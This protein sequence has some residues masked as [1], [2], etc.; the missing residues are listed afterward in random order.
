MATLYSKGV[1]GNWS[2]LGTFNTLANGTGT[3]TAP[4]AADAVIIQKNDVVILDTN[5]AGAIV[6]LSVAL[7][8]GTTGADVG[9]ILRAS[10]TANSK[11]VVER[12]ITA[13]GATGGGGA[14]T[15]YVDLNM[16]A[17]SGYTCEVVTNNSNTTGANTQN[18][19][20]GN[21]NFKGAARTRHTTLTAGISA[22]ATSATVADATGWVAGDRIIF[23]TTSAYAS[24]PA[25][26]II[27]LGTVDTGTGAITWTGG[28]TYAHAAS[29]PVGNFSS[30]LILRP[31][32]A[33]GEF[34]LRLNSASGAMSA[35]GECTHVEFRQC[36]ASS[37]GSFLGVLGWQVGSTRAL[38]MSDN[39]F[40]DHN[41]IAIYFNHTATPTERK[42]NIFHSSQT[43]GN[44]A[45]ATFGFFGATTSAFDPGTDE[46][47]AIFRGVDGFSPV[48]PGQHQIGHKI[49][50]CVGNQSS[51]DAALQ[52]TTIGIRIENCDFWSNNTA[53]HSRVGSEL[54][55]CRFGD[56]VF[57]GCNNSGGILAGPGTHNA[58]DC[59]PQSGANAISQIAA[60]NV[61]GVLNLF[62][63]DGDSAV[64]EVYKLHS[65]TVPVIDRSVVAAEYT[66][67]TSSLR[68]TLNGTAT[69]EHEISVP[70]KAGE[71]AKIL[72]YVTRSNTNLPVAGD[73]NYAAGTY[74]EPSVTLSG[75]GITPVTASFSGTPG[76]FQLLTLDLSATPKPGPAALASDGLLTLTLSAQ[77]ATA[78]AQAFFAAVPV[79]PFVSRC[80]HYGYLFDETTITRTTNITIDSGISEATALAYG[81]SGTD[82]EVTWGAT[83]SL[84]VKVDSTF[85]KIYHFTQAD[86][87]LN[88]GSALPLTGAGVDDSPAL[89]AAGNVTVSATKTLNGPGSLEMGAYTL[90]GTMPWAY[91]YTGGTFSQSVA[92]PSFSG[93]T[94]NIGAAG[95][96]TFTQAA[97]M[98][99]SATPTAPSN[100]VL[101]AATFTGTLNFRNTSA[102]NI[103]VEIPSGVT[104]NST[105]SPGAG[106][107]TFVAPVVT[108]DISITGMSNT[109]GANNRLQIINQTAVAAA[110]WQAAHAYTAGD[111]VLRTSGIGSENTAGL[112]MRCTVSGTSGA[113]EPTWDTT[114]GNTTAD[115]AGTL[116]WTTYAILYY[117][118][119]PAATSLTD[120]YIDGEE[121]KAGETVEI[122]FAEEDPAVSFK[123]YS[124]SV[125]A[126]ADGFSALVNEEADDSYATY[127][128]SGVT[129][130][131]IFSPN[132]VANYIVLDTDTNFTGSGAYAYYCYLLTT[133]EG[134]YRFWG[135][136]TGIDPGNIR[137]NVSVVSLYFD[138]SS[139]FV[140]QT[141]DIRVFRSDGLRPA[142]DPVTAAGGGIEINWKVPVNVVSTGGSALTPTESAQLLALPSAATTAAAVGARTVE[143][144][145]SEDEILKLLAAALAGQRQGI[146]T[147]TE[148]YTGLDGTTPRIVFNPDAN[149]NGTPV[150]DVT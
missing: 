12:N 125:I 62:N 77:S 17:A 55:G 13:P 60:S 53:Y 144:T 121:F 87:C 78:G 99:V 18:A 126:T 54:V 132:F 29:C 9:G 138:C 91:T 67:S 10:T 58:T 120:T 8:V 84:A 105:G 34:M 127:A 57:A 119:D 141:D 149:G 104:A 14:Y 96:Y 123:T 115:G 35:D 47:C 113:S 85:K 32:T 59:Y 3:D 70:V 66:H 106:T 40:Y 94:L 117:D 44:A 88:V 79:T 33:G 27:T 65:N 50:G 7:E 118:A 86:A 100:Y 25:I 24:P 73:V 124:T 143:G 93:G 122:R 11:I 81:N 76:T 147:A 74:T 145:F 89:F 56:E 130:D 39:A 92:E 150:L 26:D 133:S 38:K 101:S 97:S 6:A 69:I 61:T 142:L 30:N 109:V 51:G 16:S 75:L 128:T 5:T 131:S 48:Y 15:T 82:L 72:V 146:G 45:T 136:L 52:P 36:K 140:R 42:R 116:V 2:T 134:M 103:T 95:T 43:V 21:F 102:H 28:A 98:T 4:T 22:G 83:S 135:G 49:S 90:T 71:A 46:D 1:G 112:Y 64:Q 31:G 20:G 41:L 23:A 148:T 37:S 137:N 68:M 63:R 19:I 108:A 111:I 139:G 80:R 114:V 129:Q 107:V 110:D